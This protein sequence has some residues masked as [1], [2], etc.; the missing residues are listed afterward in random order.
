MKSR[1]ELAREMTVNTGNFSNIKPSVSISLVHKLDDIQDV[2]NH[3]AP[4]LDSLMALETLALTEE[5]QSINEN[6]WGMYR[7]ALE[8]SL[9]QIKANLDGHVRV[10]CGIMDDEND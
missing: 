7:S 10:L 8:S 2:Y 6:G 5:M 9:E 4:I 1:L 3:L